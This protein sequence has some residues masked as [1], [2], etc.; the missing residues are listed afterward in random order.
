MIE[1]LIKIDLEAKINGDDPVLIDLGCGKPKKNDMIGIDRVD[2]PGVN[3]VA[4]LEK[5]L[6]FFPANSVDEIHCRSVLEHIEDF[7]GL[8]SEILRALKKDGRAHIFVPHFSN[9]FFYSDYTHVKF[10]G[11]YTLYYFVDTRDQ[12]KRKVP[13]YYTNMRIK[14]I[15]Q[16]LKFRSNFTLLKPLKKLFG[17]F[18]NRHSRLQ[19]FYEE[20]LCYI[21]PCHGIEIV[22]T[23][24]E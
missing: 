4:D 12:L 20:N 21:C 7:E 6:S 17:W 16:K 14:I 5:G 18:I 2:L 22:F 19:E 3:I 24:A 10:F 1:P 13:N 15:S 8:L 23:A 11:L 9:P